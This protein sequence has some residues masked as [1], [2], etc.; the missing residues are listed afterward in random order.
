MTTIPK[1]SAYIV[2]KII[3]NLGLMEQTTKRKAGPAVDAVIAE[4]KAIW[5][6]A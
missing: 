6:K 2:Y 3:F 4:A 1:C 5:D